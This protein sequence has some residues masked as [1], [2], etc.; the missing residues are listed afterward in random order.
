MLFS[1]FS[2]CAE[3]RNPGR[4]RPGL[5]GREVKAPTRRKERDKEGAT[6]YTGPELHGD[7]IVGG[8]AGVPAAGIFDGALLVLEIDV[9]EAEAL[10]VALGPLEVVEQ[11]PGVVA[12]DVGALGDGASEPVKVLAEIVGAAGVADDAVGIGAVVV[13]ASAFGDSRRGGD[14]D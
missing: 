14:E 3:A 1:L 2:L 5:Q 10:A 4:V 8:D 12:A 6:R 7:A 13:S 9:G 11:A